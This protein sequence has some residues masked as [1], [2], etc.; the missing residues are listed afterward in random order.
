MS[1]AA[2]G[3]K[4]AMFMQEVVPVVARGQ[5]LNAKGMDFTRVREHM[6]DLKVS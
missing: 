4:R 1:I 2:D 6:V 3:L 5:A